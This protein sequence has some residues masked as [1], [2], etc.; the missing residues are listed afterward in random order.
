M[1]IQYPRYACHMSGQVCKTAHRLGTLPSF[2]AGYASMRRKAILIGLWLLQPVALWL[3]TTAFGLIEPVADERGYLNNVGLAWLVKI[4]LDR[5][6]KVAIYWGS[7]LALL[8]VE[9]LAP[10]TSVG[11]EQHHPH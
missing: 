3:Q 2:Y 7:P 9:M 5:F 4:F 8:S 10:L 11:D 1:A 6:H